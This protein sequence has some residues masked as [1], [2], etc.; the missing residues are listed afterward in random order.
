MTTFEPDTRRQRPRVLWRSGGEPATVLRGIRLTPSEA[1]AIKAAAAEDGVKVNTWLRQRVI[2]S[3]M[4]G[5]RIGGREI[6]ELRAARQ[7]LAA[8]GRN[9]NQVA[10]WLNSTSGA[11]GQER[12]PE[13]AR[14]LVEAVRRT[15][16]AV[17]ALVAK[18]EGRV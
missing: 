18:G 9:L 10:K 17:S 3:C 15:R 2:A 6:A 8:I 7:D 14:G 12:L 5:G 4:G 11:K 13:I 16:K 1:A